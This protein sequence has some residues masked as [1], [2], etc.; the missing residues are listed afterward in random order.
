MTLQPHELKLAAEL[1]ELA[2]DQFSNHGCNDFDLVTEAGLTLE[3]AYEVNK[4]YVEWIGEAEQYEDSEL[5]T[6]EAW[7]GDSG[8]MRWLSARMKQELGESD[9]L[10]AETYEEYT[11][12]TG[13]D[14]A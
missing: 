8:I 5:R 4:A 1:L 14:R 7:C 3:Q 9:S 10:G 12:R 13:C 6:T 11:K 2:A